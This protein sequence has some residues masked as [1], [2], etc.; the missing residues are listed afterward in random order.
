[1]TRDQMRGSET[2]A[3]IRSFITAYDA[4][5]ASDREI[6]SHILQRLH[7]ELYRRER[8]SYPEWIDL[9]GEGGEA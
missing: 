6:A 5:D 9:G 2:A 1:M 3:A 4:H 8:E 7:S